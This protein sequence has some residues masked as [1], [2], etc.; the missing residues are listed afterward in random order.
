MKCVG[1]FLYYIALFVIMCS[2][3][4]FFRLIVGL[5]VCNMYSLAEFNLYIGRNLL[6]EDF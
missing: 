4:Y 1:V 3:E 2:V 5:I 6:L